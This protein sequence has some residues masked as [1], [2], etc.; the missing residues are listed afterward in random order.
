MA[1]K[2]VTLYLSEDVVEKLSGI[3][4]GFKSMLVEKLLREFFEEV[5]DD[6][7]KV[8]AYVIGLEIPAGRNKERR[9]TES[10]STQ[11]TSETRPEPP[12]QRKP[13]GLPDDDIF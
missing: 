4:H 9:E 7:G 6:E 8:M 11:Q 3:K 1:K 10:T 13:L 2:A 12:K 5:G